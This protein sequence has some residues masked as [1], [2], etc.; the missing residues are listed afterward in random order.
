MREANV[1]VP[2]ENPLNVDKSY[3]RHGE[4]NR[5]LTKQYEKAI[6]TPSA[7][8]F[9][10][11]RR[12]AYAAGVAWKIAKQSGKFDD[13]PTFNKGRQKK[14]GESVMKKREHYKSGPKKGQFKPKRS[15][16][17]ESSEEAK[18]K[19]TKARENPAKKPAAKKTT[20][21]PAKKPT[22]A[23]KPAASKKPKAA[24]KPAK[25]KPGKTKTVSVAGVSKG[26]LKTLN[27]KIDQ[28]HHQIKSAA[29]KKKPKK[30]KPVEK[31]GAAKPTA[32]KKPGKKPTAK[33][34]TKKPAAKKTTKAAKKPKTTKTVYIDPETGKRLTKKDLAVLKQLHGGSWQQM[35]LPGVA[36]ENP[37]YGAMENPF[38]PGQYA[39][40]AVAVAAGYGINEIIGRYFQTSA[41]DDP[42][43]AKNLPNNVATDAKPGWK[44][45][46]AQ[47]AAAVVVGAASM[48]PQVAKYPLVRASLQGMSLG[49]M[50]RPVGQ[51]LVH[52]VF[53][54]LFKKKDLGTRLFSAEIAAD[55]QYDA[56]NAST[57]TTPPSTGQYG[58]PR[59]FGFGAPRHGRSAA[60]GGSHYGKPNVRDVGPKAA[61]LGV[62]ADG[63]EGDG[64][65]GQGTALDGTLQDCDPCA[66]TPTDVITRIGGNAQHEIDHSGSDYEPGIDQATG[67][68]IGDAATGGAPTGI[69]QATGAAIGDAATGGAPT[70]QGAPPSGRTAKIF[71]FTPYPESTGTDD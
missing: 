50:A 21:K 60:A 9:Q 56:L 19:K 42:N 64:R 18:K 65:R 37:V 55:T 29:I 10:G 30:K 2:K 25:K 54:P 41:K 53:V 20:K 45:L 8:R 58:P 7:Q 61:G 23:K 63:K 14:T 15:S 67:A 16:G 57:T 12:K 70:G 71:D 40:A 62:T 31:T 33:K 49:M 52:Y 4:L 66:A 39:F 26:Q 68:A 51:L 47:F 48:V 28:L 27:L 46:V 38:T 24:K 5:F 59:S 43:A 13:Y 11:A 17:R 35:R 34:P 22:A 6:L 69:D 44:S 3:R 1:A 36:A 32:K